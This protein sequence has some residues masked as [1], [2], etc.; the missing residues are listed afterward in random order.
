[1]QN[2]IKH[3]AA[4]SLEVHVKERFGKL[5]LLF[6]DNGKGFAYQNAL[7]SGQGIGLQSIRSRTG[8]L[9]GSYRCTSESGKG[10]EYFFAFPFKPSAY[11][12]RAVS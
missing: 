5:Y 11:D 3:A 6:A 7:Q 1:M 9:G 4:T 8:M 10:T 2:V 12:Q